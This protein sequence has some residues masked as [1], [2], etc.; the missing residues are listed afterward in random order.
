MKIKL[1]ASQLEL[2]LGLA[3][4]DTYLPT[5]VYLY[6]RTITEWKSAKRRETEE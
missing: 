6:W 2:G 3:I 5:L 1:K 4:V